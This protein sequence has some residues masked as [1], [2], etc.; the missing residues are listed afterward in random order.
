MYAYKTTGIY[1]TD[2]GSKEPRRFNVIDLDGHLG[3]LHEGRSAITLAT[4]N[5]ALAT[6]GN[7]D[8]FDISRTLA[9]FFDGETSQRLDDVIG[10]YHVVSSEIYDNVSAYASR[11]TK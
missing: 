1:K 7:V 11:R 9:A 5:G 3:F 6:I 8:R 4:K 2:V 10:K